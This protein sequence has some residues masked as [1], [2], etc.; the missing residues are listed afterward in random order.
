VPLIAYRVRGYAANPSAPRTCCPASRSHA[1]G[2]VF[3][4]HGVA[5]V[6]SVHVSRR[7]Q[8]NPVNG[9]GQNNSTEPAPGAQSEGI[10]A[11][12]HFPARQGP[13]AQPPELRPATPRAVG[14]RV[15]PV[16]PRPPLWECCRKTSSLGRTPSR[17]GL[18]P[19]RLLFSKQWW[20]IRSSYGDTC[21]L[22]SLNSG[23]SS[24]R[25][26]FI[27]STLDPPLNAR[28]PAIIS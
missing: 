1:S 25:M 23:G 19:H 12:V 28:L 8:R 7:V 14:P 22:L 17:R 3:Q 9:V 6:F 26:A 24:F 2:R 20:T 10:F 11:V 13:L 16:M 18:E 15:P 5:G 21:R 4:V 27:V